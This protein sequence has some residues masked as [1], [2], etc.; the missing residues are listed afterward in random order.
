MG[1]KLEHVK[2]NFLILRALFVFQ[3]KQLICFFQHFMNQ[4]LQI[5][6]VRVSQLVQGLNY[7]K[8]TVIEMKSHLGLL[9]CLI[10]SQREAIM[11]L[12]N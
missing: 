4:Y 11:K 8:S 9:H 5:F 2:N 7:Q 12:L 3:L 10:C 6:R 1:E